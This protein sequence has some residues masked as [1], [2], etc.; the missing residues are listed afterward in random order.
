MQ[1]S[2]PIQFLE[3]IFALVFR[4]ILNFFIGK[5]LNFTWSLFVPENT[6]YHIYIGL[7]YMQ[8]KFLWSQSIWQYIFQVEWKFDN[9]PN[10]IFTHNTLCKT[11]WLV[12]LTRLE[13]CRKRKQWSTEIQNVPM[14]ETYIQENYIAVFYWT[15]QINSSLVM[16][17]IYCQVIF[18]HHSRVSPPPP[19]HSRAILCTIKLYSNEFDIIYQIS[20]LIK[21]MHGNMAYLIHAGI[22]D[23]QSGDH[24]PSSSWIA[25][26][27]NF[28]Y[29]NSNSIHTSCIEYHCSRLITN[30]YS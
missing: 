19:P 27:R 23:L 7:F 20:A 11:A 12:L 21:H 24:M 28:N 9:K 14:Q 13:S 18:A 30:H 2:S 6:F 5:H 17:I 4:S 25:R 26:R 8:L 22:I 16:T 1:A 29:Q 15:C 10:Y 3:W